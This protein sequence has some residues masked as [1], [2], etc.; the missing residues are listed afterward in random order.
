MLVVGAF[1]IVSGLATGYVAGFFPNEISAFRRGVNLANS[2]CPTLAIR[3]PT[4]A[5]PP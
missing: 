1:L 5:S 2:R 4:W 3:P